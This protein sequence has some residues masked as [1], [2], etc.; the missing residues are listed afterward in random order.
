MWAGL[1]LT[2]LTPA[3]CFRH[4]YGDSCLI[5]GEFDVP[6]TAG[7]EHH[8]KRTG[9]Q[10][11]RARAVA[12]QSGKLLVW[13]VTDGAPLHLFKL[14]NNVEGHV[15][16]SWIISQL[17]FY[18]PVWNLLA[19]TSYIH[20]VARYQENKHVYQN[21]KNK[22]KL[23]ILYTLCTWIKNLKQ[24]KAINSDYVRE[25]TNNLKKKKKFINILDIL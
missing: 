23:Y 10:F 25:N 2:V 20:C 7:P 22:K 14:W 21:L 16:F 13:F 19:R 24:S 6:W 17:L 1:R 5:H 18:F 3:S 12:K 8:G 9:V 11:G 4:C 15:R